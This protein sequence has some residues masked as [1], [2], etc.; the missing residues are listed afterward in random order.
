M[1]SESVYEDLKDLPLDEKVLKLEDKNV[2]LQ[3]HIKRLENDI[4]K[5]CKELT[6]MKDKE[7]TL[8]KN[9]SELYNTAKLENE[10]NQ[11]RIA[12]LQTEVDDFRLRRH[13][14]PMINDRK[15]V[16]KDEQIETKK[17]KLE[18]KPPDY[19]NPAKCSQ[20]L[21]RY[22]D[23]FRPDHER[24]NSA[25]RR[26]SKDREYYNHKDVV[27]RPDKDRR[28]ID[29][30]KDRHVKVEKQTTSNYSGG[31]LKI[32]IKNDR[33]SRGK[34]DKEENLS[35]IKKDKNVDNVTRLDS[36]A[37][38]KIETISSDKVKDTFVECKSDV[39]DVDASLGSNA[40]RRRR[41]V[42]KIVN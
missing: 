7:S 38:R 22:H 17:I 13:R 28:F 1:E 6:Q 18:E 26:G 27:R 12:E 35:I 9:I 33:V 41:C 5:L 2:Q 25:D 4:S 20:S 16:G 30:K 32:E 40:N 8:K 34:N 24:G 14:Q 37:K 29:E 39:I 19:R 3:D 10:R 15:R 42:I 11:R 23:K 31:N 36:Q 21:D